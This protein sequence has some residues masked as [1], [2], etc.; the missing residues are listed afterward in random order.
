MLTHTFQP[1]EYDPTEWRL[2]R[3]DMVR[4]TWTDSERT[5][6]AARSAAMDEEYRR[7]RARDAYLMAMVMLACVSLAFIAAAYVGLN[8]AERAYQIE[9]MV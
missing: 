2:Q 3:E 4:V 7:E 1:G 5:S 6:F 9:E 8:R